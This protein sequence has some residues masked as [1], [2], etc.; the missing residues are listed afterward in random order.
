M[1]YPK[2]LFA[3]LACGLPLVAQEAP[4]PAT[5]DTPTTPG[6]KPPGGNVRG[7]AFQLDSPPPEVFVHDAA[8]DG[9]VPG[10]KLDVKNY[11]NH[12]FSALPIKGKSLVFATTPDPAGIKDP[13]K[14]VAKAKLPDNFH[15]G[16][17]MFLPG[18]GKP[19]AP[20]F[21]V[22][23]IDDA[24]RKFPPGSVMVLNLSPLGVKIELEKKPFLFK[25]GETKVIE[26]PPVGANHSS[27]MVA[28]SF[29]KGEWK[30]IAATIWAHPGSKRVLQVL[31]YNPKSK[32][33]ELRG[34][35]DVS[36]SNE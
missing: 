24:K 4:A 17:L 33:V 14:V 6:E 36:G 18:T 34:I 28:Y 32:Q 3:L 13:K 26:D 31:F 35:R 20:P 30:R 8:T 2:I 25:S 7:L 21:Q 9:S 23:V 1:K 19:G 5:A 27:G 15:S 29:N 16:I 10:V 11:L 22:K 12:E